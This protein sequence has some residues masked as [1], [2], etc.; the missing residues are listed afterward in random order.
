MES[1]RRVSNYTH[2]RVADFRVAIKKHVHD[3]GNRRAIEKDAHLTEVAIRYGIAIMSLDE[4][5]RK[6]LQTLAEK[7][8]T[9]SSI[10]WFNPTDEDDSCHRWLREAPHDRSIGTLVR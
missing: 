4:K 7:Y 2:K 5:Q 8:N 1:K 3:T 9:L 10:Q 6:L